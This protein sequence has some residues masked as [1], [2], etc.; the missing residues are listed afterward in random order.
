M[1]NTSQRLIST[2]VDN[3]KC[4]QLLST[5]DTLTNESNRG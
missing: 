4:E 3:K 1:L 2:T 5:Y